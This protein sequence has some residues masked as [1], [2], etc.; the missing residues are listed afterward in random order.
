MSAEDVLPGMDEVMQ[1]GQEA[2]A[3]SAFLRTC[4]STQL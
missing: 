1:V 4:K 3:I 2:A